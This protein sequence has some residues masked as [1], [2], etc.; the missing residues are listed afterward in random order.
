MRIFLCFI[1]YNVLLITLLIY[2]YLFSS[3]DVKVHYLKDVTGLKEEQAMDILADYE[4]TVEY[5]ESTKDKE[6]VLY[7]HPSAGELV[8]D[9]Q[10]VT[11]YVSK[12]YL[13]Q[14]YL[15]IENTLYEEALQSV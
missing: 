3:S 11:L 1:I 13:R 15:N 12:G 10:M 6:T 9:K 14:K 8:Y 4:I 7:S 5:V 2:T